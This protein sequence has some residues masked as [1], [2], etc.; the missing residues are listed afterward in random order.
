MFI[1][2]AVVL[3]G[4]AFCAYQPAELL[5][6]L[7]LLV[8]GLVD[9]RYHIKNWKFA[10]PALG[11]LLVFALL[12]GNFFRVHFDLYSGT[13]QA[14]NSY[15]NHDLPVIQKVEKFLRLL[16]H[17]FSPLYWFSSMAREEPSYQM[18][19]YG[20]Y[21]PLDPCSPGSL[22]CCPAYPQALAGS[23][24]SPWRAPS[25]LPRSRLR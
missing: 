17:R 12:I 25:S 23:R 8:F 11:V 20:H 15:L 16:L 19:G 9:I 3:A 6:A 21:F 24:S 13:L 5:V 14:F 4:M 7:T 1:F 2:P 22:G 10:L 18:K